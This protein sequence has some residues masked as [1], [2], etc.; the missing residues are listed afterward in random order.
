M[1][2]L[3]VLVQCL[4][5]LFNSLKYLRIDVFIFFSETAYH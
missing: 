2:V 5:F 4:P 3:S 1:Y